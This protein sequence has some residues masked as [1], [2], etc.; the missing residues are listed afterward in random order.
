MHFV[1]AFLLAV[2]LV[3]TAL[4]CSSESGSPA[5]STPSGGRGSV[6]VSGGTVATSDG[7]VEVDVPAGALDSAV[8]ITIEPVASPLA[9]AI[10]TVYE[11][12][13]SGTVFNAPV[14]IRL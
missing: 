9:G 2:G 4:A 10:G 12:G 14:T 6:D 7:A 3:V 8:T 11:I 1:R 5:S 13:P